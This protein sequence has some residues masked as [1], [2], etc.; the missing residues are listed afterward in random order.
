EHN[1]PIRM[2]GC[3]LPLTVVAGALAGYWLVPELGWVGLLVLGLILA[4]TDAALGQSV[5]NN[6][7]V[8]VRIRQALNVESGLNDGLVLPVLVILLSWTAGEAQGLG[9]W[10]QFT[11]FQLILGPVVGGLVGWGGG[12]LLEQ[13]AK[14]Q[15]VTPVFQRLGMLALAITAVGL[16]ELVGGNGFIA[17]F[18]AGLGVGT[19]GKEFCR[20]L[21][22]FAEA[23]GQLLGLITFVMFGLVMVPLALPHL[24]WTM[25]L[26]AL[27]SLTL[28]RM[29]PVLVSLTGAGIGRVSMAFLGWFGPRGLASILYVLLVLEGEQLH[30]GSEIF[31]LVTITVLV[32]V[33]L[34]GFSAVP[35]SGIYGRYMKH[36]VSRLAPEHQSVEAFP[37]RHP[38]QIH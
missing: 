25:V 5:V 18:C 4:P 23:E 33:F 37:T 6:P 8:P 9:Y 31:N 35:L 24:S 30:F 38:S 12:R 22:Q 14:R 10:V 15:W 3:G 16:A 21:H 29:L 32:S 36:H 11:A 7:I 34:H 17:A 19:R 1:L 26:Y 20:P 2:L 28:V 27:L 13:G